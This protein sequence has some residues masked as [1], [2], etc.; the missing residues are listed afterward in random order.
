MIFYS[1]AA[2]SHPGLDGAPRKAIL[3]YQDPHPYSYPPIHPSYQPAMTY[4]GLPPHYAQQHHPAPTQYHVSPYT[5]P[6]PVG[7]VPHD[8]NSWEGETLP[9]PAQFANAGPPGYAYDLPSAQPWAGQGQGHAQGSN[10]TSWSMDTNNEV[11]G[12]RRADAWRTRSEWSSPLP[13]VFDPSTWSG[14]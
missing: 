7:Y 6:R 8:D 11:Y 10:G 2:E 13:G 3:R 14:R 9:Q 12:E 5:L 4:E 1:L